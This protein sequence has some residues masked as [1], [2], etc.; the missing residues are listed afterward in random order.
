MKTL[1]CLLFILSTFVVAQNEEGG[2]AVRELYTENN[3]D[4]FKIVSKEFNSRDRELNSFDVNFH[5]F[6]GISGLLELFLSWTNAKDSD[7]TKTEFKIRIMSLVEFIESGE[8]AGY[9]ADEDTTVQNWEF[10][11]NWNNFVGPVDLESNSEGRLQTFSAVT[12]DGAFE[13]RSYV[14]EALA[15]VNFTSMTQLN[16]K[17]IKMDF[18]VDFTSYYSQG[19]TYLALESRI[20]SGRR[21]TGSESGTWEASEVLIDGDDGAGGSFSWVESAQTFGGQN[22]D[23]IASALEYLDTDDDDWAEYRI[24]FTFDTTEHTKFFWDPVAYINGAEAR[25]IPAVFVLL[26]IVLSLL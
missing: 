17:E 23:I 22:V 2:E 14:T 15:N 21:I 7:T 1:F 9:Q 13:V 19:G 5:L 12:Q 4:W 6:T 3:G 18:N 8:T 24:Y 16:P 11:G 25:A 26:L 10:I 20:K